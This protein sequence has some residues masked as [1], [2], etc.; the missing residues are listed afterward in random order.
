MISLGLVCLCP[1]PSLAKLYGSLIHARRQGRANRRAGLSSHAW[2]SGSG[3]RSSDNALV[4][5]HPF[6]RYGEK[7]FPFHVYY[8]GDV[9]ELADFF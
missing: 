1:P 3:P 2:P 8:W 5:G 7:D 6:G 9:L 4:G